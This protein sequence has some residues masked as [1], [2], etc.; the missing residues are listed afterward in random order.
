MRRDLRQLTELLRE[1]KVT[2][3]KKATDEL[4]RWFRVPKNVAKI[5][6]N[7]EEWVEIFDALAMS[8]KTEHDATAKKSS[9]ASTMQTKLENISAA[10]RVT[11]ESSIPYLN[12]ASLEYLV[13]RIVAIV[14]FDNALV[15]TT[16]ANYAR[17]LLSVVSHPPHVRS[18]TD[19]T[20]HSVSRLAW[21]V[22]LNDRLSDKNSW[23]EDDPKLQ[24]RQT[25]SNSDIQGIYF[26]IVLV[27]IP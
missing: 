2:E 17:T 14:K 9:S 20:W 19:K 26:G 13:P 10:F 24:A 4:S 25:G 1:G 22:L 27:V 3:R 21:A 12:N 15:E 6:N 23:S 11:V 7:N 18:F 5:G 16:G 8:A